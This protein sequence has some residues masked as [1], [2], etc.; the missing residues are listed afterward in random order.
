MVA[1]STFIVRNERDDEANAQRATVSCVHG[2]T[3]ARVMP[4]RT[5]L[6][7]HVLRDVLAAAHAS[8]HKCGCAEQLRQPSKAA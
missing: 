2:S 1:P 7:E 5:A 8:N 4:G 6:P 3:S